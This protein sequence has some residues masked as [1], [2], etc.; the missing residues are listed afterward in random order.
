MK[1]LRLI[2]LAALT[3]L[4]FTVTFAQDSTLVATIQSGIPFLEGKWPFLM[5][6]FGW[7]LVASEIMAFIPE[8]YIPANGIAHSIW[9]V[10]RAVFV[11]K[12]P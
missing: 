3:C 1:N 7:C 4:M 2:L 12:K 10:F 9:L 8:K 11:P 5:K 6:V